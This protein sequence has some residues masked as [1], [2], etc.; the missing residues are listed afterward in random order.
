MKLAKAKSPQERVILTAR[1]VPRRVIAA[2]R[3]TAEGRGDVR[4]GL[5]AMTVRAA[6]TVLAVM[7]VPVGMTAVAVTTVQTGKAIRIGRAS[8][9]AQTVQIG[10]TARAGLI[11]Q[12]GL[13]EKIGKTAT[14]VRTDLAGRTEMAVEVLLASLL[15]RAATNPSEGKRSTP[16]ISS[17]AHEGVELQTTRGAFAPLS[18]ACSKG[19]VPCK[20]CRL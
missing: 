5:R 13:I 10:L 17:V 6:M 4:P 11:G 1:T 16:L 14:T 12:I 20:E 3:M 8:P 18:G 15:R 2:M 7:T 19:F 9:T